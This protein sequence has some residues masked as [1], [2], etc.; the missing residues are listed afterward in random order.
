MVT[1]DII[2]EGRGWRNLTEMGI[3]EGDYAMHVAYREKL[4]ARR[5][6]HSGQRAVKY[7]E[8][9]EPRRANDTPGLSQAN[10]RHD[11]LKKCPST[12][13]GSPMPTNSLARPRTNAQP[14]PATVDAYAAAQVTT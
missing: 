6:E 10:N 7:N 11:R 4:R 5:F 14:N 2:G 9:R 12:E 3:K 13:K 1:P 8:K